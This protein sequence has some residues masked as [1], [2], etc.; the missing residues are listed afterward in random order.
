MGPGMIGLLKAGIDG[1]N[2]KMK[3]RNLTDFMAGRGLGI[4]NKDMKIFR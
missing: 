1:P 2:N 4:P 3:K